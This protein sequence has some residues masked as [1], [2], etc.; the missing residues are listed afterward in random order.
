MRLAHGQE[1]LRLTGAFIL[2][3]PRVLLPAQD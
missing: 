3:R 2:R 1:S